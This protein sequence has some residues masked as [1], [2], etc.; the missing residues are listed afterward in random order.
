MIEGRRVLAVVPARGGSK[1]IY[2]KNLQKLAGVPL[3][4]L[5]GLV[6]EKCPSIDR[7]VASTDHP[8]IASVAREYGIDVPFMRPSEISGDLVSDMA[9][10]RH[11]LNETEAD[12]ENQYD[13]IVM[14]QPTSP[15]RRVEHVEKVLRDLVENDYDAVWT[16]SQTDSKGHPLKQLVL[17]DGM[18]AYYDARGREII[19]RQQ[20]APTYH[21]NGVAYALTRNWLLEPANGLLGAKTGAVVIDEPLANIDLPLDLKIAELLLCLRSGRTDSLVQI[22]ADVERSGGGESRL[23]I[24]T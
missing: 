4:G 14:L 6:V 22:A 2:L 17:R 15:L 24:D 8:E 21:R 9:V 1:G 3:V 5:V 16:V 20:L 18:L 19:A 10:L 11:A 7:T 23:P 13:V 12:D